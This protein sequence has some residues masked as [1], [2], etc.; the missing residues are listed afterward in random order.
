MTKSKSRGNSKKNYPFHPHSVCI[1]KLDYPIFKNRNPY[2][3]YATGVYLQ[4]H[5]NRYAYNLAHHA[6]NI[7][8]FRSLP[9]TTVH[10]L[11]RCNGYIDLVR[12][13]YSRLRVSSSYFDPWTTSKCNALA[14]EFL[15]FVRQLLDG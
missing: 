14:P 1:R 2:V 7:R 15:K 11:R 6:L 5:K 13:D 4:I 12:F 9:N 3:E 8:T 10:V